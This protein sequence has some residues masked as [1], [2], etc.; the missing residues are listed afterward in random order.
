MFNTPCVKAQMGI[1]SLLNASSL[2]F[3]IGLFETHGVRSKPY[4]E[5]LGVRALLCLPE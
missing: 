2:R 1:D 3:H 4:A 5:F